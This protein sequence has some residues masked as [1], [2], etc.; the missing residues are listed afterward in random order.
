MI[1]IVVDY[2]LVAIPVPVRNIRNI[3]RRYAPVEVIE[4][5]SIGI[6]AAK[7]PYMAPAQPPW[8]MA[9]RIRMSLMEM[10]IVARLVMPDPPVVPV[11]VRSI[12]VARC[13]TVIARRRVLPV[14]RPSL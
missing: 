8:E 1:R 11:H 5:K 14:Y 9:M 10:W 3:K 13:I 6:A 2:N 12:W 7:H 4:P